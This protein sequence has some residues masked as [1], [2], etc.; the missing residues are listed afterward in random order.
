MAR[1]DR[2]G[3]QELWGGITR[4]DPRWLEAR[5]AVADMLQE[6]LDSQRMNNDRDLVRKRYDEA[7]SLL[8]ATLAQCRTDSERAAVDLARTRLELTPDAG[9]P[10]EARKL[11]ELMLRSAG[12]ESQRARARRL[13][14][15]AM[16]E[17]NRYL[18]AEKEARDEAPR[19]GPADLLEVARLL[20]GAASET[21][22]DLRMRRLGLVLR[23]VVQAILDGQDQLSS[24]DRAEARLRQ[25]RALLL[26][27]DEVRAR[28]ALTSG[29]GDTTLD[30]PLL[31]D[32]ADAY[33]RIG[34]FELAA[35]VQRLRS[36]RAATGSLAWFDSRYGLALANYRAG[37]P[38]DA[39][40]L[41]DATAILHPDLGGGELREKFIHL[42]QRL[43]PEE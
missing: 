28:A 18:E 19:S 9:H 13:H 43:D 7:R 39:A 12:Q 8:E 33:V 40:R 15:V 17:L 25:V 22:S 34:A 24:T 21:A 10:E 31:R 42:R 23:V 14:V 11:C 32:L 37:K 3:A 36:Q 2:A 5:L 35:S 4:S 16:A 20:D 30:D 29:L 38:R 26:S 6:E 41:I 27:G 1:G